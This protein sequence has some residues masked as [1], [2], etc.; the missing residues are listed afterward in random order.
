MCGGRHAK[1]REPLIGKDRSLRSRAEAHL[2]SAYKREII[3]ITFQIYFKNL[4]VF[5]D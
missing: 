4:Y 3:H 1:Q 2:S 5:F